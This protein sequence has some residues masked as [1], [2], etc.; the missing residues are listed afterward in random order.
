MKTKQ[1][2]SRNRQRTNTTKPIPDPNPTTEEANLFVFF[3][4]LFVPPLSFLESRS[5]VFCVL[6]YISYIHI[7]NVVK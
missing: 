4:G 1:K 2:T 6:T 3:F 5:S 7:D